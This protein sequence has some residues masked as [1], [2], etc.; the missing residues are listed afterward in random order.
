MSICPFCKKKTEDKLRCQVCKNMLCALPPGMVYVPSGESIVGD[1]QLN[2]VRKVFLEGFF[3]DIYP[4]T[5]VEYKKFDSSFSYRRGTGEHPAVSVTWYEAQ[6][7]AK[8]K[9]KRLPTEDEWEKA[10][11]GEDGNTYPWGNDFV[12]EK[13]NYKRLRIFGKITPVQA[14]PLGKSPY[15]CIDM[16]GNI[17]EWTASAYDDNGKVLKGGAWSSPSKKFLRPA[18]RIKGFPKS[19]LGFGFRCVSSIAP[20]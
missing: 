15:G 5:N 18:W 20:T 10:G 16:S 9:G 7:Y 13:C 8:S 1:E 14:F 12:R 3:I 19:M 17:W 2:N 6:E 4:V 11:R